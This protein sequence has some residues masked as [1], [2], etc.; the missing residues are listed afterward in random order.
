MGYKT[1]KSDSLLATVLDFACL[2]AVSFTARLCLF[3]AFIYILDRI[4][5][6]EH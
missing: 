3:L 4:L 2:K 6:E 1:L 5:V